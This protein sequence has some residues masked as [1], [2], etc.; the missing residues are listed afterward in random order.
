MAINDEDAV[1]LLAKAHKVNIHYNGPMGNVFSFIDETAAHGLTWR[2]MTFGKKDSVYRKP[3][4][5]IHKMDA[6]KDWYPYTGGEL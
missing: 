3:M 1:R 6:S 4:R 5:F 2:E